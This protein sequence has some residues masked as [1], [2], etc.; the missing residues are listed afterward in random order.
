MIERVCG[1]GDG[2][3][4][5]IVRSRIPPLAR[6]LAHALTLNSEE[7]MIVNEGKSM[8]MSKSMSRRMNAPRV[9]REML[10]PPVLPPVLPQSPLV[11]DPFQS[12]SSLFAHPRSIRSHSSRT[13]LHPIFGRR[14]PIVLHE[15]AVQVTDIGEPP[16]AGDGLERDFGGGKLTSRFPEAVTQGEPRERYAHY[17]A[18]V[19][20]EDVAAHGAGARCSLLG[21]QG[22]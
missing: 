13:R 14:A 9:D 4:L 17:A 11:S 10:L 21:H 12:V 18:E 6:A 15:R 22:A 8:S 20:A 1:R 16:V 3:L 7:E 2:L 19:T 5:R